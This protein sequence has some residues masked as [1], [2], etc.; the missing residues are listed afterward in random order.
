VREFASNSAEI[1][2]SLPENLRLTGFNLEAGADSGSVRIIRTR[3]PK[4]VY[5]LIFRI[6]SGPDFCTD[7]PV[8]SGPEFSQSVQSGPDLT[9][10]PNC[11]KKDHSSNF[12]NN[13]FETM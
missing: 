9:D 10:F 7:Y 11:F 4:S 12:L 3:S 6:F 2:D 1:I 5:F 8:R 13:F